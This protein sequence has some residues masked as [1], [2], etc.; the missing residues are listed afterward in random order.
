MRNRH[1]PWLNDDHRTRVTFGHG[2]VYRLAILGA[3]RRH[4]C[5]LSID[6][7]RQIRYF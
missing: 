2:I 3:V 1:C 7:V 6:L 4:R 5:N